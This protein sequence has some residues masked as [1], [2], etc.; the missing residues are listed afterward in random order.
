M[1][2]YIKRKDRVGISEKTVYAA[3]AFRELISE[4]VKVEATDEAEEEEEDDNAWYD[5]EAEDEDEAIPEF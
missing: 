1:T 2:W 5:E 3:R 4:A